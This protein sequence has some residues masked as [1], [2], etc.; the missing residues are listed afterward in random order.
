MQRDEFFKLQLEQMYKAIGDDESRKVSIRNWCITVWLAGLTA[1]GSGKLIINM[2]QAF[3]LSTLPVCMFWLLEC[4]QH[5]FVSIN[6]E[7]AQFLESF[8]LSNSISS[9]IPSDLTFVAGYRSVRY[10]KKIKFLF[11]TIVRE[12]VLLFYLLLLVGSISFIILLK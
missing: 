3:L 8:L 1:I 10:S 2:Y 9:L 12:S 7:R 11:Q 5:M 4:L 6:E